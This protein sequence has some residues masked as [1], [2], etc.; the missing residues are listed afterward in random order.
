MEVMAAGDGVAAGGGG[1][2]V[3]GFGAPLAD[4]VASSVPK[5]P[6][7]GAPN[8]VAAVGGTAVWSETPRVAALEPP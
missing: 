6:A 1:G 7:V 8:R 3:R 2:G 4:R 5:P